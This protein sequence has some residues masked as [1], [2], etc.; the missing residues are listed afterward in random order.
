LAL[1]VCLRPRVADI[2]KSDIPVLA[3]VVTYNDPV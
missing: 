3:E 1:S 2:T